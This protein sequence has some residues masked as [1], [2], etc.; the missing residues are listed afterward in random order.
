MKTCTRCL[1]ELPLSDFGARARSHDGLKP[2]CKICQKKENKAYRDANPDYNKAYQSERKIE[3]A[4]YYIDYRAQNYEVI[5]ARNLRRRIREKNAGEPI[6]AAVI[7]ALWNRQNGLCAICHKNIGEK[8]GEK[9][10]YHVDH[11]Q[12]ISK[13]GTND[14]V[15]LQCLC[16]PCNIWKSNKLPE[17]VAQELGRLFI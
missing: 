9:W 6:T 14:P 8:P 15:N 4:K 3:L 11:I 7:R 2:C 16:P 5:R 12:P 13:G 10:A 1:Q 17:E